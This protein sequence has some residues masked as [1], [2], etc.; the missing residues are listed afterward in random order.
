M[1]AIEFANEQALNLLEIL[2]RRLATTEE[3]FRALK[4]REMVPNRTLEDEAKRLHFL[5]CEMLPMLSTHVAL[6]NIH[7]KLSEAWS[8]LR[9]GNKAHK[10]NLLKNRL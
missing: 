7:E 4:R 10:S 3:I 8:T 9:I 6:Q 2:S 5:L 1:T